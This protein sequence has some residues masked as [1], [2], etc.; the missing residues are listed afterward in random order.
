MIKRDR[1]EIEEGK[2]VQ[3][4]EGG[5]L[6]IISTSQLLLPLEGCQIKQPQAFGHKRGLCDAPPNVYSTQSGRLKSMSL[7]KNGFIG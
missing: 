6:R 1:E 5:V 4:Q 3:T 2:I 7:L